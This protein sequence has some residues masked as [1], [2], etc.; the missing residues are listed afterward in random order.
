[1]GTDGIH[2][3]D[4]QFVDDDHKIYVGMQRNEM[5]DLLK[6]L[7]AALNEQDAINGK[8]VFELSE[9]QRHG[10]DGVLRPYSFYV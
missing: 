10:T 1:M 5:I 7:T 8:H 3:A 9:K 6:L 4:I 2:A